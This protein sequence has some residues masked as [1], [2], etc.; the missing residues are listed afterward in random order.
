[1]RNLYRKCTMQCTLNVTQT[2]WCG[3]C[4]CWIAAS[5]G[6]WCC[7]VKVKIDLLLLNA[8][9]LTDCLFFTVYIITHNYYYFF[10]MLYWLFAIVWTT[11]ARYPIDSEPS[12][13]RSGLWWQTY[14]ESRAWSSKSQHLWCWLGMFVV[15]YT[16]RLAVPD[17][18]YMYG[19]LKLENLGHTGGLHNW[20]SAFGRR[21][22][23]Q[24]PGRGSLSPVATFKLCS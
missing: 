8:S 16:H 13:C 12:R 24:A 7:A 3:K 21:L 1:M 14:V 5:A 22:Q 9:P 4:S 10:V 18:T 17:E 11:P 19:N 6:N 15:L 23:V 20:N 2:P